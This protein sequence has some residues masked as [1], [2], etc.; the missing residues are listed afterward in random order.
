MVSTKIKN[1]KTLRGM[2]IEQANASK[3]DYSVGVANGVELALALLE[4]RE[5]SLIYTQANTHT[6]TAENA[7]K[8]PHRGRTVASGIRRKAR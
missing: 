6:D 5:P 1:V 7:A 2:C 8:E 4:K 3:D